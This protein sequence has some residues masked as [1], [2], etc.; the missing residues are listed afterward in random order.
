[1]KT[2][3]TYNLRCPDGL[4][5]SAFRPYDYLIGLKN[6]VSVGKIITVYPSLDVTAEI[7]RVL[8]KAE[9]REVSEQCKQNCKQT[10]I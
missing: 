7:S 8:T 9:L 10:E 6:P 5:I 3:I 1:M 4:Y 2:I